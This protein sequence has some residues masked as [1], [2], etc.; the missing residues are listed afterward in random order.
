MLISDLK[1]QLGYPAL[2]R[3]RSLEQDSYGVNRYYVIEYK[4]SKVNIKC[5]DALEKVSFSKK[6][7]TVKRPASSLVLLL[8]NA[9]EDILDTSEM[10]VDW[11][12][13]PKTPPMKKAVQVS[14]QDGNEIIIDI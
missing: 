2:G 4:R 14:F 12:D 13:L 9:I 11:Q 7:A 6:L 3:I 8:E 1:G 10:E 5:K